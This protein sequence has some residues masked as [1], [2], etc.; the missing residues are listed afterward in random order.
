MRLAQCH[1]QLMDKEAALKNFSLAAVAMTTSKLSD[2]D[3]EKLE[4]TIKMDILILEQG[5]KTLK[6][7]DSLDW[8]VSLAGIPNV[9][10]APPPH[11]TNGSNP[12]FPN[13]SKNVSVCYNKTMGRHLVAAEDIKPGNRHTSLKMNAEYF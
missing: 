12:T 2:A 6:L 11:L 7:E 9:S 13:I 1:Q 10:P 3:K 5:M 8:K 4:N